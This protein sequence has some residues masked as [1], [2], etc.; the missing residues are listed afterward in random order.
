MNHLVKVFFVFIFFG[1]AITGFSNQFPKPVDPP[2]MVNDFENFLNEDDLMQLEQKLV[3]FNNETST[4]IA[5]VILN[6]LQGYDI[7]QFATELA[8]EWGIGQEG[9]DNGIVILLS[10][11]NRKISIQIGYGLEGVV[12]DAIAKRI[13]ENEVLPEFRN[14]NYIAG[15]N[16]GINTLISLTRGEFTAEEYDKKT[17]GGALAGIIIVFFIIIVLGSI[18]GKVRSARHYSVGHDIP[19]WL[20]L[21]MMSGSNR[22]SSGKFGSFSSGRGSF[23]GGSFGGFGGGGFGGGGASGSW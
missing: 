1:S 8:H 2:R 23:G 15:L 19:F 21:M 14:G 17:G 20:A 6:D 4:Q 11:E 10:P 18:F 9:K 5:L 3:Q 12:P 16:N 22:G 13:I 7:N